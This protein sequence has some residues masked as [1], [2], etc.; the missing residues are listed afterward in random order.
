ML[1]FPNAKINIGL[2]ILSRREDG[3]H[4][5]ETIFLPVRGLMDALE[6]IPSKKTSL[7]CSGEE[8]ECSP[9]HNLVLKAYNLLKERFDLPSVSIY[10]RK[11][12]PSGA[13]L[14]GG[15][16]DASF[17]LKGLRDYFQLPLKEK[18]LTGLAS[19]MG[20]DC[21]FFILN[22]PSIAS[23]K[24]EILEPFDLDLKEKHILIIKPPF[25]VNTKDAYMGIQPAKPKHR[26]KD[27][28]KLPL[29]EWKESI[30]NDFEPTVFKKFPELGLIKQ[31]MYEMG[32]IYAAMSGSGSAIF[33]IFDTLPEIPKL[34]ES[35]FCWKV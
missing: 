25:S 13:G 34:P 23:G 27:L 19:K 2:N 11:F 10:L 21:A 32:A 4:N 18:E 35:Y 24:G 33:G 3:F 22:E 7:I 29:H 31:S 12:I 1:I 17:M 5:I 14:G 28:I 8:I 6:F 26:L 9:S 15:S 16:S 30:W 20:S